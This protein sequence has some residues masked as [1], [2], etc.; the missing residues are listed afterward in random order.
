MSAQA[1]TKSQWQMWCEKYGE[2]E[3]LDRA[4]RNIADG[5]VE[6]WCRECGVYVRPEPDAETGYC[7][8][9]E[10]VTKLDNPT[11]MILEATA[12]GCGRGSS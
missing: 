10:K 9:C 11:V 1:Q 7:H 8:E 5:V 3:I 4:E 12:G 2:E 6:A